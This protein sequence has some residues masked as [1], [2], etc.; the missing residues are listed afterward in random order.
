V[1]KFGSDRELRRRRATAHYELE[2]TL[3]QEGVSEFVYDK[4]HNLFRFPD[5]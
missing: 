2:M 1:S 3:R 4:E 5:G